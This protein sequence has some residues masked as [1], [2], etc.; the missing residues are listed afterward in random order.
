[1]QPDLTTDAATLPSVEQIA[2]RFSA[3]FRV[4][5]EQFVACIEGIP[6]Q[7]DRECYASLLLYRLILVYVLQKKGLLAGTHAELL[8]GDP[9]YLSSRLRM[10]QEKRGH[11]SSFYR[12][13]LLPFFHYGLSSRQR[14]DK[15]EAL[16]GCVPYLGEGLFGPHSL[17]S[18]Y[19]RIAIPDRAFIQVL[20]FFKSFTWHLDDR[21]L[22]R[23]RE[24]NLA[25]IG[26]L[27]EKYPHQPEQRRKE[28][29]AYY[30]REDVSDY[31]CQG[32]LLPALF[33]ELGRRCPAALRADGPIWSLLRTHP[34]RYLHTALKKGCALPMPPAIALSSKIGTLPPGFWHA[35]APED[36][37]LP[38]ETWREAL[39]RRQR[40]SVLRSRLEAGDICS[41]NDLITCNLNI[42]QLIQDSVLFCEQPDLLEAFY[43]SLL[44]LTV[45]DPTCGAGAFLFAAL[46]VLEPLY[47]TCLQ[48]MQILLEQ[49]ELVSQPGVF[50]DEPYVLRFGALLS[51]ADSAPGRLYFI[52]HLIISHNLYGVDM[53]PEAVGACQLRLALLLITGIERGVKR[54]LWPEPD[55]H[56]RVGN[57]LAGFTAPHEV[58][59]LLEKNQHVRLCPPGLWLCIEQQ[60]DALARSLATDQADIASV[61]VKKRLRRR[62]RRLLNRSLAMEYERDL[63][64]AGD[65]RTLVRWLRQWRQAVQPFHWWVEFPEIMRQHGF[66][67]IMGNPP[68]V[69]YKQVRANYQVRGYQTLAC[70]NLYA[71]VLERSLQLLR[72]EGRCGM[73]VPISAIASGHYQPLMRLLLARQLWV[74][75]YSNRPG[76]LFAGVEQRLA[77]ILLKNVA[78][79]ALFAS[80]Y[81]HWYE[82]ERPHL[83]ATL[84]YAPASLWTQTGLPLKSGSALAERI[85]AR[86]VQHARPG[87]QRTAQ[88]FFVLEDSEEA[89]QAARV[90]VLDQSDPA[91]GPSVWVHDGPTYWVRA[92]PFAPNVGLTAQR[93]NHYQRLPVQSQDEAFILSA[94]L[95]SSTF[96]FFYKLVSNCRDLSLKELSNFPVG[97]LQP[98]CKQRLLPLGKRLA[99][100][101]RET[102]TRCVRQYPGGQVVYEEYHPA[103]AR[104]ILDSIDAV[105][106]EHY[107]LTAEELDFVQNYEI[108][109]RLGRA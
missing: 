33:D 38:T 12:Q 35:P 8:D 18:T 64:E 100:R 80:P 58:K 6:R 87:Q 56:I 70:G 63:P 39:E 81:R 2:K 37:A 74:S 102:A 15:L 65:R 19:T 41:I 36:Y 77:I 86:L 89:E 66:A 88:R 82:Q 40:Y 29:G 90:A 75:S 84:T 16:L 98:V 67:V 76:K 22:R 60:A 72:P 24:L 49:A 1:M 59:A 73:I 62:L 14:S 50:A 57:A 28:I 68:Y 104:E 44:H 92:L 42:R 32:A 43:E 47:A 10:V 9:D 52:Y 51:Q 103:C 25:V 13:F 106:A 54:E 20:T 31:I 94:I 95:S 34:E 108:K 3:R 61:R 97:S 21:P 26:S 45:L 96:Y 11:F 55:F 99:Q 48:R 23:D 93:S 7:A 30:T 5:S 69:A 107:G 101:L 4:I 46:R 109:Y 53:M 78:P 17:E 71:Y 85:F 83:F 79:S 105:L 27:F 91:D